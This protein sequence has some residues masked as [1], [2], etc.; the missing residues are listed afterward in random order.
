DLHLEGGSAA[1]V[2][3]PGHPEAPAAVGEVGG[4]ADRHRHAGV[5]D[6]VL[7]RCSG[8]RCA[9]SQPEEHCNDPIPL[10]PPGALVPHPT[11]PQRSSP[12]GQKTGNLNTRP[13]G[14][15]QPCGGSRGGGGGIRRA[16]PDEFQG[17][18]AAGSGTG[19]AGGAVVCARSSGPGWPRRRVLN[20]AT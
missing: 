10:P 4:L 7:A 17:W 5:E 2:V 15:Q 1:V 19:G 3:T 8:G 11:S 20:S 6:D 14:A 16:V 13:D 12:S 9:G 18:E